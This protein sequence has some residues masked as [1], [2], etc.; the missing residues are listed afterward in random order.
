LARLLITGAPG[1]LG[2]E[3]VR[4][5]VDADHDVVA[6]AR[7]GEP[8]DRLDGLDVQV[9][10]GDVTLPATLEPAFQ[11]VEL[12][13]H[14]AGDTSFYWG[15]RERLIAV[16][17][18]GVAN[19]IAAARAAGVRRLVHTSSV[20]AVGYD[21]AGRPVD[22]SARWN[23]PKDL[24]YM[25]TKRDG[26]RIALGASS[27]D[28]EV[29]ALNPA[30]IYGP[31]QLNRDEQNL[32]R[33]LRRG[34]LVI[35]PPGGIT[36]CDVE[37][38]AAAHLTA[39][40]RGRPGERYILG[41]PHVTHPEFFA[42]FAEA[43]GVRPPRWTLPG[44]TLNLAGA[45]LHLGERAGLRLELPAGPLRLAPLHLY[46]CCD[47]AVAELGYQTRSLEA[48]ARRTAAQYLG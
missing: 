21:P 22:E 46:H 5:A 32:M 38:V 11:E 7:T 14:V 25:E 26:E 10:T 27:P 4:Q 39:L 41:G 24:P 16:N 13:I 17:V 30:T 35:A 34:L 23:W 12:C 3:V 44:W 15:D 19:V 9:V 18:R 6:F 47:R 43:L 29:V 33:Q 45:A 20:A 40:E 8:L 1:F 42:A 28:L 37:D 36:L 2:A 48:I 31:G